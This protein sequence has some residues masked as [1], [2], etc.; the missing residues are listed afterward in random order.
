MNKIILVIVAHSDDEA[1]G[2]SGTMAKHV[3]QGDSVHLLFMTNGVGSRNLANN[4]ASVRFGL[5]RKAADIVGVKSM[6]NLDFP[7]NKMDTVPLLD[8]TQ[9]VEKSVFELQPEIIYTHHVG[10]LNID[11]QITHKAVMTACRPLP[12]FCVKEIYAFEV[13]SSTEWQSPNLHPFI[14][15][16]YVNIGEFIGVKRQLLEVYQEEM[17]ME[18]H[19]RSIENVLRLASVR[20]AAVGLDYAEAFVSIRCIK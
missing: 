17:R 13:L 8:V 18:P 19:S 10:D 20:G 1:L 4:G 15:N 2:C 3:A 12:S 7:D 5:A 6:Q 14:P 16:V 9:A 11:H